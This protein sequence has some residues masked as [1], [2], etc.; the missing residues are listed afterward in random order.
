MGVARATVRYACCCATV[1]YVV[2]FLAFY[3]HPDRRIFDR[4]ANDVLSIP[5]EFAGSAPRWLQ[6]LQHCTVAHQ[7]VHVAPLRVAPL[8]VALLH[9]YMLQCAAL[10]HASPAHACRTP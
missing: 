5:Q 2:Y 8:H 9:C 1:Q 7:L 10:L 6:R 4:K 3:V